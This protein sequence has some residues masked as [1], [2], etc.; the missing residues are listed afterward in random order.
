MDGYSSKKPRSASPSRSSLT[1]VEEEERDTLLKTVSLEEEDKS[2]ENGPRK[3][4]RSRFLYAIGILMLSNIAFIAAFLTVFVQKRALE[5]A[6]LP[7]WAPPERYE[8]RVFKYMDVYGGEPGPKSEEA[9]TNLIPKGKGWIKVHNETAIP[10]MPGLDQSLP[11]QSA[12]VSV[13]HQLHCLYMTRAGYF[14]ARSGNLDEVN[15]VHVSHCWDYLRQAI[16][17][18]SDTTLEWLHAPPD[19]FGST[20]WGYEHQC[21]DYEAI[22]AFATEHRAGERQVIHG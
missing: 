5:P 22:F 3:L 6:R 21:R 14:A 16:M 1:E 12:L 10:D 17:C 18:H 7:P 2:G 20:G 11:E 15:V 8:S 4:R 13:F 9:W 19:N